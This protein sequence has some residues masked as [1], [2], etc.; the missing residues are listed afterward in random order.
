MDRDLEMPPSN[1]NDLLNVAAHFVGDIQ[2]QCRDVSAMMFPSGHR[3]PSE[4]MIFAAKAKL[5][6]IVK[7][8]EAELTDRGN[9]PSD[10]QDVDPES[11]NLLVQ[12]GFLKDAGLI[13]FILA[14]HA[15]DRLTASLLGRAEISV[16]EQLP[17]RL[18]SEADAALADAAQALLASENLLRY[19]PQLLYRELPPEYLH[20]LVWRIVAALQVTGG[21]RNTEQIA[22]ARLLLA[23]QDESQSGRVAARKIIH[24][25]PPKYHGDALDPER[26]GLAVFVAA[27]SA[28]T[29][30][31][32]DHILRL[33]DGHSMAPLAALLRCCR[34]DR[35]QAM[36]AI[37]L[38]RS[39]DLTPY[40]ISI[41]DEYYE[42]LDRDVLMAM[43][44]QWAAERLK[45]LTIAAG[46]MSIMR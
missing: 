27:L 14:R 41:F 30:L 38:F 33:I 29:A 32:H 40:E 31:E 43:A 5:R 9:S 6:M 3:M 37:C 12:S 34:L 36:A 20:L 23:V 46:E 10:G 26:S 18:M 25:L 19:S 2:A 28:E 35:Q 11:W 42:R 4:Q 17:A 22:R 7:G 13:D 8:I 44:M 39:F 16:T 21:G 24:F 15:E 45:F 1:N